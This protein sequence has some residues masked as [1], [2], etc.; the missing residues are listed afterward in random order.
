M[1]VGERNLSSLR[2]GEKNKSK[3]GE[4]NKTKQ[5]RQR[6]MMASSQHLFK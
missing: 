6:R 1:D 5:S 4:E 2:A 3:E